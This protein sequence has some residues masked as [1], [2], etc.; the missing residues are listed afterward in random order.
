M[1]NFSS[2]F[3]E[4]AG[5]N[6]VFCKLRAL[7][8]VLFAMG[9]VVDAPLGFDTWSR[10]S[11]ADL[12]WVGTCAWGAAVRAVEA[13]GQKILAG[14]REC[15]IDALPLPDCARCGRRALWVVWFGRANDDEV[16]VKH[17][18]LCGGRVV[19]SWELTLTI[20]EFKKAVNAVLGVSE[21]NKKEG[22][23]KKQEGKGQVT[24]APQPQAL[25]V[26]VQKSLVPAS[27]VVREYLGVDYVPPAV[28][29]LFRYV[30]V[31]D[32]TSPLSLVLGFTNSLA[33]FAIAFIGS[34]GSGKTT[35]AYWLAYTALLRLLVKAN[36]VLRLGIDPLS[37]DLHA[38]LRALHPTS[39]ED[40]VSLM[41][42][43]EQ[44]SRL[45]LL[46]LDDA[47]PTW[48]ALNT[49]RL[50]RQFYSKFMSFYRNWAGMVFITLQ[51]KH[52]LRVLPMP[53]YYLRLNAVRGV[54][55][56]TWYRTL[57]RE[58][59]T[60]GGTATRSSGYSVHKV[61]IPYNP[62]GTF[63]LPQD[64]E[65]DTYAAKANFRRVY[66][67]RELDAIL[68]NT[69]ASCS[70]PKLSREPV[71]TVITIYNELMRKIRK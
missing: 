42:Y 28:N 53:R 6:C 57:V 35:L 18:V 30:G 48:W 1:S 21:D 60:A 31:E 39:L 14:E 16:T 41:N 56:V 22:E 52:T 50:G 40:L 20:D 65:E 2:A 8:T 63:K 37:I 59:E 38:V 71:R 66:R 3:A 27:D 58:I 29:A 5:L 69:V 13:C 24:A 64:F 23:Q 12:A 7:H 67:A 9:S 55:E 54:V 4:F 19:K 46:L 51:Y 17:T 62:R 15:S 34:P 36:E 47:I 45:P 61:L 44:C 26:P 70:E 11:I 25:H 49:S 33:D 10:V 32:E 43:G 68:G